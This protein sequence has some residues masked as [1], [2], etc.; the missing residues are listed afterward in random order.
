MLTLTT[1]GKLLYWSW[2]LSEIAILVATCTRHGKGE[3]RDQ[4]S[5]LLLWITIVASINLGVAFGDAH[6]PTMF[7]GAES[8]RYVGVVLLVL[9]LAIRWTAVLSL[10]GSFSANVA[11]RAG[12]R[13]QTGGFYRLVQHPSYLGLLLVIVAI[14]LHTHNWAGFAI[15]LIPS[16]AA[17]SYR[18]HVEEQAL[19][20]AFGET[21][22]RYRI[23]T[24]RLFPG[25]Y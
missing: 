14:G 8:I 25:V 1:L 12:Q 20:E 21:Y 15:V 5:L 11:V 18:M 6:G 16:M 4:G 19:K 3:I 13:L 2:V 24:K 17:L 9:G 10:G 23:R 22:E 7:P